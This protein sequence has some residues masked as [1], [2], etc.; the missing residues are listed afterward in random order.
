MFSFLIIMQ[1]LKA[2]HADVSNKLSRA[3]AFRPALKVIKEKVQSSMNT[4]LSP[5]NYEL[6]SDSLPARD[7]AFSL[8]RIYM[9]ITLMILFCLEIFEWI[10][11]QYCR[12]NCVVGVWGCGRREGELKAWSV[13]LESGKEQSNS[14]P[15][16]HPLPPFP[17]QHDTPPPP[18]WCA[19]SVTF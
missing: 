13:I 7:V 4:L 5:K 16:S 17:Q 18:D 11:V 3:C 10:I 1:V 8:A 9:G 12:K 19:Y 6:L 14:S 2:F 15:L